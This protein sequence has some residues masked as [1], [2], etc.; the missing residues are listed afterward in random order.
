MNAQGCVDRDCERILTES[1]ILSL[2]NRSPAF[3]LSRESTSSASLGGTSLGFAGRFSSPMLLTEDPSAAH[4]QRTA[5][6]KHSV[7]EPF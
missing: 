5:R 4:I 2:N 1:D 7:E 3:S 6:F